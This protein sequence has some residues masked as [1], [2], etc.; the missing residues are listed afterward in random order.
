VTSI[1]N[2][3]SRYGIVMIVRIDID[4]QIENNLI[5]YSLN[6]KRNLEMNNLV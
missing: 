2:S 6:M 1:L 5:K 4:A 3:R